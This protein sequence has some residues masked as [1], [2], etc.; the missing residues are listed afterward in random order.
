MRRNRLRDLYLLI[1]EPRSIRVSYAVIYLCLAGS[2]LSV[3]LDTPDTF[4]ASV[5]GIIGLVS[6][7]FTALG[8]LFGAVFVVTRFWAWERVG[9]VLVLTG[10]LAYLLA[11][12]YTQFL[13]DE[14]GNR[15]PTAFL[16]TAVIASLVLRWVMIRKTDNPPTD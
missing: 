8:G 13:L 9:T 3:A 1:S 4:T 14:S 7:L 15:I 5:E 11:A 6:G 2:G 12:L 16:L 10:L